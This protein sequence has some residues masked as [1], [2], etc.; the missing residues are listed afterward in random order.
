MRRR[1]FLYQLLFLA[2]FLLVWEIASRTGIAD[3]EQLPP[4]TIVMGMLGVLLVDPAFLSHCWSTLVRVIVAFAIGAPLAIS[5]GFLLGEKMHLGEII[6]PIIHFVLAVPQS[7]FLPVFILLFGIGFLEKV[8]FG[9]T[10]IIF[11][12][13]VNTVAAVASVPRSL[14]LAARSFGATSSQ[15]YRKIYLPAMAPL[16]VTGLRIGMIFNIIGI[17]LAEM[18][19]S[20]SGI[21]QLIFQW[22]EEQRVTELMA[23]IVIVSLATILVN[24]AMRLWEARAGRWMSA[25]EMG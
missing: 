9:V 21:G 19:A 8:V 3:A 5:I 1:A 22:G 25:A 17:L 11:V 24:E 10:H 2:A 6:N 12:V 20:R 4:F 18:Y 14:V 23:A 16:L 15:I 13:I 7:I